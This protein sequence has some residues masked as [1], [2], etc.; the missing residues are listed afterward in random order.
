MTD[1]AVFGTVDLSGAPHPLLPALTLAA[2]TGLR[3]TVSA[4]A[5]SVEL[6]AD[7]DVASVILSG[8]PD[9]APSHEKG[10]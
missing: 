10:K 1:A 4:L 5:E 7:A 8:P 2:L 6:L 3:A 9:Q